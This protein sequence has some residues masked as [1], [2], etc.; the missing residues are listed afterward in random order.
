MAETGR[1]IVLEGLDDA[2]LGSLAE[3]LCYGL[4]EQGIAAE[5]TR[6]P[7]YGPAGAQVRLAQQGRLPL[8]PISLALLCLADRLDHLE[9]EEGIRAWLASGRHVLCVHYALY[10]YAWQWGQV[11][12][13]WQRRIDAA[14]RAP[15]LTLYVDMP[16]SVLGEVCVGGSEVPDANAKRLDR[17]YRQAIARLR[18]EGQSVVV[19]DGRDTLDAIY[20]ACRCHIED[21]SFLEATDQL[22]GSF[23][24]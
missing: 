15:D 13:D 19:V 11:D 2:A 20:R 21:L 17:G 8:D 12:W 4:R 9:R 10:A 14:C 5:Y 24:K 7:T 1:L 22:P 18:D 6:E 3:R 16:L 23:G